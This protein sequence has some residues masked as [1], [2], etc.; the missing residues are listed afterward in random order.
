MGIKDKIERRLDHL[1]TKATQPG[2]AALYG[3]S[4]GNGLATYPM[5]FPGWNSAGGVKGEQTT[6]G[7]AKVAAAN[8]WV[9]SDIRAIANEFS[10]AEL[11]VQERKGE[12]KV[13]QEAHAFEVLWDHPNEFMSRV[14]LMQFW[15]WQ[16]E[17]FGEAYFYMAPD[18]DGV[19]EVWPIPSA[20]IRPEGDEQEFIRYYVFQSA[21]DKPRYHIDPAYICYSRLPNPFDARRGMAPILALFDAVLTDEAMQEWNKRFFDTSN[22]VPSAV[23]SVAKDTQEPDYLRAREEIKEFFG[24]T[25]RGALITRAGDIDVELLS[26][27]HKEMDFLEGRELSRAEIDR[28][29]GFPEG[30][31]AKDATRANSEGAKATMIENAVH[32]LHMILQ[33]DL[34]A[35]PI[36]RWYGK[37]YLVE[38][39]DIRPRNREL[40]LK[41]I[42]MFSKFHSE[43]EVREKYYQT[44]K[45]TQESA[46]KIS[47]PLVTDIQQGIVGVND[48]RAQLG[49]EPVDD[50]KDKERRELMAQAEVFN[51]WAE[52]L[53][54]KVAA[55]IVGVEL[56]DMPELDP[57]PP[58][59][60]GQR[61]ATMPPQAPGNAAPQE[62]EDMDEELDA[63][64]VELKRWERK[65]LKALRG[66]KS[67]NV[68]FQSS[69]F[70]GWVL[71]SVAHRLQ[72]ALTSDAVKAVFADTLQIHVGTR[73]DEASTK[74][75]PDVEITP[76]DVK[77]G[78]SVWDTEMPDFRGL[79][80]AGVE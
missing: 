75:T 27:G 71:E 39:E 66:G 69:V 67:P 32:P 24:G 3:R 72:D 62:D 26:Y 70:E 6:E 51:K 61:R 74:A 79:L 4:G 10:D 73:L 54:P 20:M 17:L 7:R 77:R 1:A 41:E 37:E 58:L 34:T 53:P 47:E 57:P 64:A 48:R 49:L 40:E 11:K 42:E 63:K 44:G 60:P 16:I 2:P 68:V 30:F 46:V 43:D 78:L 31:W 55:K 50:T 56:P 19:A 23:I 38:I 21:P 33:E 80:D 5:S 14:F 25:R 45:R 76:A 18:E 8:A 65:A 29:L 15:A 13:D 12:K 9:Y 59:P 52:K 36:R 35:Q 28:V 22:A